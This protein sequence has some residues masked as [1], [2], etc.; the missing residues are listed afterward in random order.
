M[1]RD[2][3]G[4]GLIT[5]CWLTIL[6]YASVI[7][8]VLLLTG[9]ASTPAFAGYQDAVE[10]NRYL[11]A[12]RDFKYTERPQSQPPK[13][14][15]PGDVGNC[16]DFAVTKC[17]LLLERGFDPS[18]LSFRKFLNHKGVGH[19]VC[20]VDQKWALD[21]KPYPVLA[22]REGLRAKSWVGAYKPNVDWMGTRA[23]LA[24]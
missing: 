12:K 5:I 1:S 17:A 3:T 8:A 10:V 21:W 16:E 15:K 2:S 11:N 18:R 23:E 22:T 19:S 4:A 20:V 6:G 9:C 13:V 24:R 14:M 7:L